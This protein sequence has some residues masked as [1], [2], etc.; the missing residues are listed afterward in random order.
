MADGLTTLHPA[1]E[2]T[3]IWPLA[4]QR[5]TDAGLALGGLGDVVGQLGQGLRR[6]DANAAGNTDPLQDAGTDSIYE[7]TSS[8]ITNSHSLL[9]IIC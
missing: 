4:I 5:V 8:G 1:I 3:A 6:A 9:L 2:L 7:N